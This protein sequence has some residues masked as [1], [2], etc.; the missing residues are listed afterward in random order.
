MRFDATKLVKS[1]PL[2]VLRCAFQADVPRWAA[3]K[4]GRAHRGVMLETAV[5]TLF[6]YC[7][8]TVKTTARTE[9][10]AAFCCVLPTWFA[11]PASTV[12]PTKLTV[13]ELLK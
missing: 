3:T 12:V 6:R 13:P 4:K 7:T 9:L 11:L 2:A 5:S 1:A 8:V 10:A